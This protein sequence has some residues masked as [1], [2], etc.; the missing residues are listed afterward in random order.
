MKFYRLL[1]PLFLLLICASGFYSDTKSSFSFKETEQGIELFENGQAVFFYQRKPKSS[2]DKYIC[3]N[4]LHPLYSIDGDTLTEEFPADHP[5]HRGVFWAWHQVFINN[6][7]IGDSWIMQNIT[8][9]VVGLKTNIQPE[10]AH[11]ELDVN[12]KSSTW[13]SGKVFLKEHTNIIVHSLQE[14]AVRTIDFEI[15]LTA[16]VPGVSIGGSD[17]E[18]GYGGF[19]ARIKC[20]E[21]LVFTSTYGPVIPKD[22]QIEAG[23]WLDFS[24]TFGPVKK[25]S[26]LTLVCH[27]T[28]PNY[29][30]PWILRQSASMQNIV[31]PGRER[32]GLLTDKPIVLRYRIIIHKGTSA[33]VDMGRMLSQ[34]EKVYPN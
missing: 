17:N 29:P 14:D 2:D 8:Q 30:A 4:Y 27:P 18:K 16:L 31:F 5:F 19:S 28:T 34:Y 32:I 15:S 21:D 25:I 33:N 7:S 26:G 10:T 23:P 12:W 11:L 6:Q 24:G 1:F 9:D 22:N 20:P 13:Q 3:N